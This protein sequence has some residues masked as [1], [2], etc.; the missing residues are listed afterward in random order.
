MIDGES[1]HLAVLLLFGWPWCSVIRVIKQRRNA[2]AAHEKKIRTEGNLIIEGFCPR[3][4][5]NMI[6]AGEGSM[7]D[8]RQCGFGIRRDCG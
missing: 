6:E 5:K 3:V 7:D 1:M 8:A 2:E 4:L